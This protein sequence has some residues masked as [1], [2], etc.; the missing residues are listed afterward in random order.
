[1]SDQEALP[2]PARGVR[3]RGSGEHAGGRTATAEAQDPLHHGRR[4]WLDAAEKNHQQQFVQAHNAPRP[5]HSSSHNVSTLPAAEF[6]RMPPI[7]LSDS[8]L[9]AVMRGCARLQPDAR[10]AFLEAV[11]EHL[12]DREI[13]DGTVYLAIAK[14]QK[15]FFAR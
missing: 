15:E 6:R 13:G 8:Q 9:D 5:S 2:R 10:G 14:A 4:Y 7:K 11:A 1:M 12:Q 3:C